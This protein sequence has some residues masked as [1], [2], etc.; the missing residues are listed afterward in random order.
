MSSGFSFLM[1]KVF[2][3]MLTL[4]LYSI[5]IFAQRDLETIKTPEELKQYIYATAPSED[6]FVAVQMLA[7]P[8]IDKKDWAGAVKIFSEYREWFIENVTRTDKII[9]LLNAESKNLEI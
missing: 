4:F 5:T 2:F 9:E 3:I 1:N 7:K 6:A 8:Y